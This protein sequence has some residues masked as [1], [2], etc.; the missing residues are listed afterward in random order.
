MR[1]ARGA[2]AVFFLS[3]AFVPVRAWAADA[4]LDQ[5]RWIAPSKPHITIQLLPPAV[6]LELKEA[7]DGSWTLPLTLQSSQDGFT[8]LHAS[9]AVKPSEGKVRLEVPVKIGSN[10]IKVTAVDP[11]G[12]VED[13]QLVAEVASVAAPPEPK[14]FFVVGPAFYSRSISRS[15]TAIA[16][17]TEASAWL[18]GVRAIFRRRLIKD[19][20]DQVPITIKFFLDGSGTIGKTVTGDPLAQGLPIWADARLTMEVFHWGKFRIEGGAGFSFFMP[21]MS[22]SLPGDLQNYL[23]FVL[24]GRVGHPITRNLSALAGINHGL[25]SNA[26]GSTVT[27]VTRPLELFMSLSLPRGKEGFYELRFKYNQVKTVGSVV[28]AGG[29]ERR[30]VFFGPELL[31]SKRF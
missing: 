15:G 20:T 24:S 12:K 31:W 19:L 29:F 26:G 11:Y 27:L 2:S 28:A 3:L 4:Q 14:G 18:T 8:L 23:G 17:P 13:Y 25:A 6:P 9:Q 21:N 16:T 7:E 1:R 30:E 22:E 5:V 10:S